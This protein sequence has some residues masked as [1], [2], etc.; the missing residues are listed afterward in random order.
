[1]SDPL[2]GIE[3]EATTASHSMREDVGRASAAPPTPKT[4]FD[5][6]APVIKEI[7]A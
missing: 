3:E 2:H 5:A 1:M 4:T 6:A 7:A